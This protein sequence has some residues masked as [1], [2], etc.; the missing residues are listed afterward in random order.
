MAVEMRPLYAMRRDCGRCG[1]CTEGWGVLAIRL[2]S[3][4]LLARRNS[5]RQ[6]A[7][8][9]G[10]QW[11]VPPKKRVIDVDSADYDV[12]AREL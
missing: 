10:A 2:V 1:H 9:L 11:G 8:T 6:C 7:L 4:K 5:R 3:L 12:G